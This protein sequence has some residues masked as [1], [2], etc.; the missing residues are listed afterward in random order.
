[1]WPGRPIANA[2]LPRVVTRRCRCGR[3][4]VEQEA[5]YQDE[6]GAST[7]SGLTG[8]IYLGHTSSGL[9]PRSAS[10]FFLAGSHISVLFLSGPFSV[11]LARRS[12]VLLLSA[13]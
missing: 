8:F 4:L 9:S 5:F 10:G 6:I 3:P 7:T 1:M 13:G 12:G 2:S 11:I